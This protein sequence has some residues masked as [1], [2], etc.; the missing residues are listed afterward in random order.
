MKSKYLLCISIAALL[1]TSCKPKVAKDQDLPAPAAAD[2][3]QHEFLDPSDEDR[4]NFLIFDNT[5]PG[6]FISSW[7]FGGTKQS[8]LLSDTAFFPFEGKYTVSLIAASKGGHSTTSKEIFISKT[9]PLAAAFETEQIDG[10]PYRFK[11]TMTTKGGISQQY[12]YGS[13]ETSTMPID[14]V[15]FPWAGIWDITLSVTVQKGNSK[16]SS[17]VVKQVTVA[18]DDPNNPD[19]QDPIFQ[20]LTGGLAATNGKTWKLFNY[21][22][23]GDAKITTFDGK[24]ELSY[25]INKTGLTGASW[26][27]GAALNEFNFNIRKY[28]YT[29]A[30]TKSTVHYASANAFFGK[31]QAQYQ[32][33]ALD[34]PNLKAAPFILK[35]D[36][37]LKTPVAYRLHIGNGSYI[38]YH[39]NRSDYEIVKI[40]SDTLYI[41]QLYN[42]IVTEDPSKDG[43]A[44]YFTFV[45]KK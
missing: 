16:F 21:N 12:L 20:L 9:S 37:N 8:K 7:D 27:Q 2:F 11:V 14:T 1:Y 43:N 38:A 32:D 19:L 13:G 23:V 36:P 18:S 30:N 25:D 45:A 26:A 40:N 28:Q 41:R 5:T 44:R 24:T 39:E 42:D 6:G 29:P 3:T 17:K 15:Y 4:P 22:G 34:D 10:D 33:I 31:A 35:H